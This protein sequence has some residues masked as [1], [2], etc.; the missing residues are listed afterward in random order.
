MRD[1]RVADDPHTPQDEPD[2]RFLTYLLLKA[3]FLFESVNQWHL[4]NVGL[5]V[6]VLVLPS[7]NA[8]EIV[9]RGVQSGQVS[10]A[11]LTAG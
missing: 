11:P 4:R 7:L 8:D 2:S 9:C 10:F 1:V 6:N 3:L 5:L